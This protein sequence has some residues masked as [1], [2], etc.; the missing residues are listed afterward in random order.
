MSAST[1]EPAPTAIRPPL[2][3]HFWLAA[4]LSLLLP[5][6]GQLY[7]GRWRRAL[8]FF[9]VNAL[10]DFP[11]LLGLWSY[12]TILDRPA[13]FW[14]AAAM[15]LGVVLFRLFAIVDAALVARR[16]RSTSRAAYQRWYLY[17]ALLFM[18]NAPAFAGMSYPDSGTESY[19]I[20]SGSMQPT[21][22]IGDYVIGI[23]RSAPDEPLARGTI[24]T[25]VDESSGSIY[26]SRLIG[27]PGDTVEMRDGRLI[28]NGVPIPTEPD[29]T[30]RDHS[31]GEFDRLQ[32]TLPDGTSYI[33]LDSGTNRPL[34][35]MAPLTIPAGHVFL[36]GDN[37]DNARDDR[38][39]G[40]TPIGNLEAEILYVYWS[41]DL[42][43]VGARV[44]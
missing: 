2:K 38:V 11:F 41:R 19:S 23:H 39:T 27:L 37:R 24:I 29:G 26:V 3:R 34:D 25:H 32:E 16:A 14:F 22:Q 40:P 4:L 28:L 31:G 1:T 8:A 20:P 36:L 30:W 13:G 21:L 15:G 44:N 7:A 17:V 9:F 5:G 42:A 35:D 43:R 10:I 18:W 6:L 33:V 12:A